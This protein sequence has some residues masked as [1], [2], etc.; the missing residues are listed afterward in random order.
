MSGRTGWAG[1][2]GTAGVSLGAPGRERPLPRPPE[3]RRGGPRRP[4]CAGHRGAAGLSCRRTR[5]WAEGRGRR[6]PGRRVRRSRPSR[7]FRGSCSARPLGAT[8]PGT[9]S[10]RCLLDGGLARY[11]GLASQ[12]REGFRRA[13]G[14]CWRT[15]K[16][17]VDLGGCRRAGRDFRVGL[18]QGGP[19]PT[20]SA[21]RRMSLHACQTDVGSKEM[22]R[23]QIL[24]IGVHLHDRQLIQK[25]V[26]TALNEISVSLLYII[27]ALANIVICIQNNISLVSSTMP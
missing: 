17:R 6:A 21:Q 24:G 8:I 15:G 19:S 5:G 26:W 22:C 9:P 14:G 3:G 23:V 16:R 27:E 11:G 12:A 10:N 25:V 1:K 13:W 20:P 2:P 18:A 7:R 4:A